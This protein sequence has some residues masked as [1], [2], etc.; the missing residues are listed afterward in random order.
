MPLADSFF[1]D[2]IFESPANHRKIQGRDDFR[3]LEKD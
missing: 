2:W 3:S 1:L